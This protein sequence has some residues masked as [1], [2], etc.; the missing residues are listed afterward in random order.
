MLSTI[1]P[2]GQNFVNSV[3]RIQSR[4]TVAQQQL[5]TGLKVSQPSDAP[6]QISPILQLQSQIQQNQDIQD[7]LNTALT[8]IKTGES[9]LSSAVDLLQSASVAAAKGS[10]TG[11]TAASRATLAQTVQALMENMV[12]AS[13]TMVSGRYVFS[14]DQSE[15]PSYQLDLTAADGTGV[16][17]L[18]VASNTALVQSTGGVQY[19]TTLTANQIFDSRNADGT[20]DA[21]NAFAALNALRVALLADDSA[22][23]T[24]SGAALSAA[25]VYMNNQL[26]FYGASESRVSSDIDQAG[27]DQLALKTQLSGKTDADLT[28]AITSLT[29]GATQMQAALSARA[30][31]PSTSL[32]DVLPMNG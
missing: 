29:E 10:G 12:A 31:M 1:S 26:A 17:R 13:R 28:E 27:N 3:N 16:A 19:S 8:T 18:Q 5:S 14:G 20:P 6:D 24:K 23:I 32:F 4:L 2:T 30:K 25:S 22:G 11:Q 7:G 15:T 21:N 9:A